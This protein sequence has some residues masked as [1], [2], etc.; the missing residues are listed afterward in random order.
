MNDQECYERVVRVFPMLKQ[1]EDREVVYK[2]ARSWIYSL[3]HS[4]WASIEDG[5]YSPNVPGKKL[6]DH[7][8]VAT[9]GA[10][11]LA[12]LIHKYHGYEFDMQRLL[13]LG[14]MHDCCKLMEYEPDGKG[15]GQLSEYG[16]K[17]PHGVISALI[18]YEQGF[19]L[20]M[21]HLIITHSS[22]IK[23]KPQDVEGILFGFADL[24]DTQ[25]H[26]FQNGLPLITE[27]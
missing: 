15:G 14:L 25:I 1:V 18:A 20:E 27:L 21:I 3:E 5:C 8:R 11:A 13:V 12:E 4:K 7:V 23:N 16:K 24:A 2:V 9:E 26:F 6:A 17:L 19:N 10:M 22:H